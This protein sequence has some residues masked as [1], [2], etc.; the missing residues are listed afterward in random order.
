MFGDFNY[1]VWMNNYIVILLLIRICNGCPNFSRKLSGLKMFQLH[2]IITV[3][4][5]INLSIFLS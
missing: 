3:F 2:L 1:F 5:E 4:E